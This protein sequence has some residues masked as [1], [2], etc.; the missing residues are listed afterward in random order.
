MLKKLLT[1]TLCAILALSFAGICANAETTLHEGDTIKIIF[2]AGKCSNVAGIAVDSFYDP[3]FVE[4]SG[5]P[6]F[7]IDGQGVYNKN[8]STKI[9]WNIMINGGRAFDGEDIFV[10]TFTVKKDCTIEQSGLSFTCVE[11]FNHDLQDLPMS[12]IKARLEVP[13]AEPVQLGVTDLS[14]CT[15]TLSQST[16]VA[17]GTAK[18][19]SVTVTLDG[20]T[21]TEGTDYTVSYKDNVNEGKA[22]VTVTGING[23]TGEASGTFEITA[24][25]PAPIDEKPLG[26]LGDV[27]KDDS[28]NATDA[29]NILRVS[30]GLDKLDAAGEKLADIDADNT[31]TANDALAVLRYSVGMSTDFKIGEPLKA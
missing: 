28:V 13:G 29:L 11:I 5:D 3:E 1:V 18:T 16:Y 2:Y 7:E 12:L 9:K 17:D 22:T 4:L 19:P 27:N 24:P 10:E 21:L 26:L 8:Y 15:V 6:A 31:I 20:K 30:I 25:K 14:G 23:Y